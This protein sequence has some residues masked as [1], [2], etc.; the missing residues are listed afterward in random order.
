MSDEQIRKTNGLS[1]EQ[2][3]LSDYKISD[4]NNISFPALEADKIVF[5]PNIDEFNKNLK[6]VT[7]P[8][9]LG[10][11]SHVVLKQYW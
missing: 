10:G 3:I 1:N 5:M 7:S 9:S 4:I 2:R 6:L 8:G 11:A